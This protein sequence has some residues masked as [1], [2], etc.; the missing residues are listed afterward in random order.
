[1]KI[2]GKVGQRK[3]RDNKFHVGGRGGNRKG[4]GGNRKGKPVGKEKGR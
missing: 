1:V 3:T 4:R 2:A